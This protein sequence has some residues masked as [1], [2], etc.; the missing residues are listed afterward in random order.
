MDHARAAKQVKGVLKQ[1]V[2]MGCEHAG[3]RFVHY[4]ELL[5]DQLFN[6]PYRCVWLARQTRDVLHW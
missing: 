6:C 2:R 5:A 3:N 4:D 1:K